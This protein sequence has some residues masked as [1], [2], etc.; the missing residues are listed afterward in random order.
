VPTL[1]LGQTAEELTFEDMITN[2]V[3]SDEESIYDESGIAPV[4]GRICDSRETTTDGVTGAQMYAEEHTN[5]ANA[6]LQCT[7][8]VDGI[9]LTIT[10]VEMHTIEVPHV[11]QSSKVTDD[12][13]M[14]FAHPQDAG[15]LL[16]TSEEV[17]P[18]LKRPIPCSQDP[19]DATCDVE[20]AVD[21]RRTYCDVVETVDLQWK[22]PVCVR[23]KKC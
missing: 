7:G 17:V 8:E 16:D 1:G 3:S 21:E 2:D 9:N 4:V 18:S 10:E 13:D 11:P 20:M 23:F 5:G 22:Q 15:I 14:P 12:I 19:Q 6:S